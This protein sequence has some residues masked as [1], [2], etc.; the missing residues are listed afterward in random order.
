MERLLEV[1]TLKEIFKDDESIGSLQ[2]Y[3]DRV[4]LLHHRFLEAQLVPEQLTT[5]LDTEELL[6]F[7]EDAEFLATEYTNPLVVERTEGLPIEDVPSRQI[8]QDALSLAGTIFE[9]LGDTVAQYKSHDEEQE[10]RQSLGRSALFYLK[11]ALCYGLGLYETRTYVILKRVLENLPYPNQPMTLDNCQEW[12][13]Y[14]IITLLGRSLRQILRS[15]Q[16]I[17]AQA[18]TI[19]EQLRRSI[20]LEA[21]PSQEVVLSPQ[22]IAKITASLALIDASLYAAKALLQGESSL[23]EQAQNSLN[24]AIQSTHQLGDYE[25]L[26]I[27]RTSSQVLARMWA[28]SPWARLDG[29]ITRRTYLKKLVEDGIVTLWSS[30]IAALEMRSKLG[31]LNGGYLDDQI[32]RVVIHM[33]TSAGKTLLAELAIAHQ[34]FSDLSSKCVYVAPSR[35][36]CDQ[37]TADLAARLSRFKI[38]VTTVVSDNDI[39]AYESILFGQNNV[40]VVTPEKLGYLIR[41]GHS[42]VWNAKLFIFDELHNIGRSDRGWVYEEVI[43]LLLQHPQTKNN[44][45]MFLSAIMP[46]YLT[47]QEWVDPEKMSDTVSELWQPTRLLKG[48]VTFQYKRPISQLVLPGNLIYVRRKEDLNSPLRINNFIDSKQF[49]EQKPGKKPGQMVWKR[50]SKRSDNKINHAVAAAVKF[51]RLGPVLVYSP[52]RTDAANFCELALNY[53]L[54]WSDEE[55][56]L[57]ELV[58]FIADGLSNGHPL[59]DALRHQIAFHHAGLPRDV[60]NEIEYAFRKGW[61]KILAATTTL[62]EGVNFPVKT[63]LLSDYCQRFQEGNEE[64]KNYTLLKSD[65]RNIAGRAGRALYETEGQVIFIQSITGYPYGSFDEGYKDYLL[66]EPESP[67]LNITSTLIDEKLLMELSRLVDEVD[68]GTLSEQQLLFEMHATTEKAETIKVVTR[69]HT[70]TLL[71]QNQELVGEDEESFVRIFQGT[72]LGKL[73]PDLAP[74]ILGAFSHRGAKAINSQINQAERELFAR[75][76]LKIATCRKLIERV[77]SYWERHNAS[78]NNFLC[79]ALD[80]EILYEIA[81][82]V[83]NL[84][85][86]D[87]DPQQDLKATP[88]SRTKR[89]LDD[90]AAFFTEWIVGNAINLLLDTIPLR[91]RH[92]SF[93]KEESWRAQQYVNYT[94]TTLGYRAP[95]TLSAFWLFSKAILENQRVSLVDTPLGKEL[96]LL[97]A[98][99]KFGVNTPAAALFSTLGVSPSQLA[100]KLGFLYEEQHGQSAK[101]AYPIMLNWLLRNG[102]EPDDLASTGRFQPSHIRRL[103]RLLK[104]LRPLDGGV[105]ESER[106]WEVNFTIAGWQYYE[107]ES[108]LPK[109]RLGNILTLRPEPDNQH[110]PDAVEVLIEQDERE[111]KLGYVPRYLAPEV[112]ARID[113]RQIRATISRILPSAPSQNKVH[114]YC[115]D[116]Q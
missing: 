82:V 23:I 53:N 100:R 2:E 83:Y 28:N 110:D 30:Q 89:G 64:V 27:L 6:R 92:F 115:V 54:P 107:G 58:E 29:I 99:A 13:D 74:Q 18:S 114:V 76:G 44:K 59:I 68:S 41:Q 12:A 10:L 16:F 35:A 65:F 48:V 34:S 14:L 52:S 33:P 96:L 55:D 103:I 60:R 98:Y 108:I 72:F 61:I 112:K 37:V 22:S 78:L 24:N 106:I 7:A 66:L 90:D 105:Q 20:S 85:D 69:L 63:L 43:S 40:I 21:F 26:W 42:F 77:R 50:N 32:K 88:T 46:N 111:V 97:P 1:A 73:S 39:T 56:H 11:S 101:Y 79:R 102:T 81:E 84:D 71:L 70:L 31:T 109:L 75:T 17:E 19:R 104:S 49:L 94:Q 5:Q 8:V 67:A 15:G 95:W 47:V 38:R 87:I 25:G 4:R 93:I 86:E 91:E 57:Q 113:I 9:F 116:R 62:V 80:H 45:M 36:L 51:A 3:A